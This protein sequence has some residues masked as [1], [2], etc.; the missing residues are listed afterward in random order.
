MVPALL[1]SLVVYKK[2]RRPNEW[3][4]GAA[5]ILGCVPPSRSAVRG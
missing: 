2:E 1:I 3:I 5:M 4:A